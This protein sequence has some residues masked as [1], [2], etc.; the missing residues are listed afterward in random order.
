[1]TLTIEPIG[2]I[3]TP[4]DDRYRAPRQ[5][6]ASAVGA[7]GV[8]TLVP[9]MNFEQALADLEGFER[10]W[11][12]YW[13]DRNEGWR[14]KV[15]PPRGGRVRRG[16]FA[17]RS[18]HRPNP[19]G[20]SLLRLLDVRGR[21]LR[22]GD[23]DLLD[24]TPILDIKPYLP[25]AEAWPDSRAGWLDA[26]IDEERRRGAHPHAVAWSERALR[27]AGWLAHEHGIA[28]IDHAEAV[29]AADPTPHPYRRISR[30]DD[31]SLELAI[32][33]W[34]IVFELHGAT[35]HVLRL[36]SGYPAEAV[37][38]AAPGTL[39]D[40]EAHV[41]FWRMNRANLRGL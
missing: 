10:I 29:L 7:E 25:Y 22:V 39:H 23:V 21:T 30:R 15:L 20:L 11:V 33:S 5:P 35:V 8:I 3:A 9:G 2:Y 24:G 19:L 18:P 28:L 12:I 26:V 1:V 37:E 4:Y 34:R 13:F 16:V 14:P 17:T 36:E 32:K 38:S 6:G 27:E 31:G 40:Q 41:E